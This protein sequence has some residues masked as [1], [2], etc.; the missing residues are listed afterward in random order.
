MEDLKIIACHLG[1]GG[2]SVAA[3][4]N[5]RSVDTSMGYTPLAGLM[6]STRTG[7]LDAAVILD[8]LENDRYD[9]ACAE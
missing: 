5:G 7:D 4:R 2:S 1:T 3:I 6:M 8:I 9:P